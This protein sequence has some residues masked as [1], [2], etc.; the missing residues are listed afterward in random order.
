[1]NKP[2][3]LPDAL[4]RFRHAASQYARTTKSHASRLLAL[5]EDMAAL[6]KRGVSC[7]A[8]SERLTPCAIKTSGTCVIYFCHRTLKERRRK[9]SAA[10]RA[11]PDAN[12]TTTRKTALNATAKAPLPAT[13]AAT[14]GALPGPNESAPANI[15]G[16][17]IAKVERLPVQV[18]GRV[19]AAN[20]P[21]P[22]RIRAGFT[23]APR[24]SPC[25]C[26][27][28]CASSR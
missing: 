19:L 17:H 16:P 7:R 12:L 10:R 18:L 4:N 27:A 15:R 24:E 13:P 26:V 14:V 8:I 5:Q 6:R 25:D 28:R 22:I 1:M 3:L 9:P 23:L 11:M 21:C 2:T 20:Y